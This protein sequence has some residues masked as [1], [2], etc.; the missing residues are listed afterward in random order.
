MVYLCS[1]HG[2][3][4]NFDEAG[5]GAFDTHYDTDAGWDFNPKVSIY[6]YKLVIL[7][8]CMHAS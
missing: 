5:W 1:E 6:H 7:A 2:G 4:K 8:H 3:D